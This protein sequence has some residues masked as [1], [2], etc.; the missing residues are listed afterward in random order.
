MPRVQA[1]M[2]YC[3]RA[4][5]GGGIRFLYEVIPDLLPYNFLTPIE[6]QLWIKFDKKR[7]EKNG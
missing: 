4:I 3:Q 6:I 5:Y 7:G 1:A 2:E